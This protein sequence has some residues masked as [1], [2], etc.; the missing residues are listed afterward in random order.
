MR[1]E[2]R[3][4]AV[5][6]GQLMDRLLIF[7]FL[8]LAASQTQQCLQEPKPAKPYFKHGLTH[9][10]TT[11]IFRH[12]LVKAE[13][14]HMLETLAEAALRY[15]NG[16]ISSPGCMRKPGE[17]NNDEFFNAQRQAHWAGTPFFLEEPGSPTEELMLSL[18][19]AIMETI[20]HYVVQ[21][22][23]D[24]VARTVFEAPDATSLQIW[25]TIHQNC[26]WHNPH[27]H[28]ERARPIPL[29]SVIPHPHI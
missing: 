2:Q 5:S 10:W 19:S 28:E 1:G 17:T 18:R 25:A 13:Q 20:Q 4:A 12:L 7:L 3:T 11:P 9:M 23:G 6:S 21:S 14:T 29:L 16:Y 8:A 15:Y 27:M 26:S 24:D 22:V